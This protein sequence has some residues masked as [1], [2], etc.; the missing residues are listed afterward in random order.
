MPN[1]KKNT[2]TRVPSVEETNAALEK[3]FA[4][5]SSQAGDLPPSQGKS[6]APDETLQ[7]SIVTEK[8]EEI[9]SDG[10][11]VGSDGRPL[12]EP[13]GSYFPDDS[14]ETDKDASK[15]LTKISRDSEKRLEKPSLLLEDLRDLGMYGELS[16]D[17]SYITM[18]FKDVHR[19][20]TTM[21]MSEIILNE[22]IQNKRKAKLDLLKA[23]LDASDC[24]NTS[25][26]LVQLERAKAA[27]AQ[28]YS[29][30]SVG[31]FGD[32]PVIDLEGVIYFETLLLARSID[33]LARLSIN[34]DSETRRGTLAVFAEL[35]A[36]YSITQS[37][38]HE[39]YFHQYD[40]K[41]L[42]E[43]RI[44]GAMSDVGER[45][46]RVAVAPAT[47]AI[48]KRQNIVTELQN[49][50]SLVEEMLT[51]VKRSYSAALTASHMGH[52]A[53]EHNV[54][55]VQLRRRIHELQ[56][57]VR[58]WVLR[59]SQDAT[60]AMILAEENV[61][62]AKANSELSEAINQQNDRQRKQTEILSGL[63]TATDFGL[64][65]TVLQT[66]VPNSQALLALLDLPGIYSRLI[67]ELKEPIVNAKGVLSILAPTT[68]ATRNDLVDSVERQL[69]R[70]NDPDLNVAN[71]YLNVAQTRFAEAKRRGL[72][73]YGERRILKRDVEPLFH[74]EPSRLRNGLPLHLK[75]PILSPPSKRQDY[76]MTSKI[77]DP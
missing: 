69:R 41:K 42:L 10:T 31:M 72:A 14:H 32:E 24:E 51:M 7:S 63:L 66:A 74:C 4:E 13:K 26:L 77:G 6:E 55:I 22:R 45:L 1:N 58:S 38:L 18:P 46:I 44:R 47:S 67:G 61:V 60:A 28:K 2:K 29:F 3:E 75:A 52:L 37:S 53:Y 48:A 62:L 59:S 76:W 39:L 73:V 21:R 23:Q 9:V 11:A 71:A 27:L 40:D 68:F 5:Q 65:S 30:Q 50:S 57:E 15:S 17:Q 54:T 49:V 16:E 36:A 43:T 64:P 20:V 8:I 33:W 12:L 70:S 19:L 35:Q 34:P 56:Q 25:A